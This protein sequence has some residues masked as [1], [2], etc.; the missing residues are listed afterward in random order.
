MKWIYP[1]LLVSGEVDE[2]EDIQLSLAQEPK[3]G[4]A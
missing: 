2:I 4:R 1:H 3:W